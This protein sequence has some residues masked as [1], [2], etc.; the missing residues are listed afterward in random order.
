MDRG[1]IKQNVIFIELV[2]PGHK[3]L[4][5]LQGL[6]WVPIIMYPKFGAVKTSFTLF[7][8]LVTGSDQLVTASHHFILLVRSQ[9]KILESFGKI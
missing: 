2:T 6:T 8:D 3:K 4:K 5:F 7:L 1:F 9:G